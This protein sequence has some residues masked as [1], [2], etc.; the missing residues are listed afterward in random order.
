MEHLA[1]SPVTP[2]YGP[3]KTLPCPQFYTIHS[4]VGQPRLTQTC[5]PIFPEVPNFQ[6]MKDA[7]CGA[8]E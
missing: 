1:D 4:M 7:Y 5:Q 6:S 3:D 8:T 2:K